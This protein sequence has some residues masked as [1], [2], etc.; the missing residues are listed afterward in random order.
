MTKRAERPFKGLMHRVAALKF[1]ALCALLA[2]NLT[3]AFW[4]LFFWCLLFAA[5]WLF[6]LPAVLGK[7]FEIFAFIVF[8]GGTLYL[9][10]HDARLFR[11]PARAEVERRLQKYSGAAHQPLAAFSDRPAFSLNS[12]V[13]ALWYREQQRRLSALKDLR[14]LKPSAFLAKRDPHALRALIVLFALCGFVVAG[15]E[16]SA[17]M[18][19]GLWPFAPEDSG[20]TSEN[21]TLLITPPKY[22]GLAQMILHGDEKNALSVPEGSAIK[23]IWRRSFSL[24]YSDPALYI[25]EQKL[26]LKKTDDDTF[27]LETQFTNGKR[28]SL[29]A[30]L[31]PIASWGINAKLDTPPQ[32]QITGEPKILP[33]GQIQIPV[34][35]LDDYGVKDLQMDMTLETK[36]TMA[37]GVDAHENRG[38]MS[39][40]QTKFEMTPV[41]DLTAHPWAG[42][43]ALITLSARDHKGQVAQAA[44]I[45]IT[46]PER[47]FTNPLAQ[48]LIGI[49]KNIIKAPLETYRQHWGMLEGFLQSNDSLKLD[50]GSRMA[51]RAAASRMAYNMPSAEVSGSLISLLW[52]TALH[53]EDGNLSLSARALKEAQQ[54]LQAALQDPN[55]SPQQIAQMMDKVREAMVDYLQS[56]A[57]EMQKRQA[58]GE[59][60]EMSPE[61]FSNVMDMDALAK[62]F[63]QME[64]DAMNGDRNAAQNLLSQLQRFLDMANPSLETA[65]PKDVEKMMEAMKDMQAIVKEQEALLD[66]T[67]KQGELLSMLD[68][69]GMSGKREPPPF[70][71]PEESSAKQEGLQKRLGDINKMLGDH[72]V[73]VPENLSSA[74]DAMK[75]AA[76][77][78][79]ESAPDIAAVQQ[80]EALRL[81]KESQDKMSQQMAQRMQ[82]MTGI[83][84]F[85]GG[86]QR[87]DPLGRPLGPDGQGPNSQNSNVKIPAEQERQRLQ[88]IVDELRRRAGQ[89]DRPQEE[90]EYYRR[91]LKRF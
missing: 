78:L 29:K 81:L 41:Y 11:W 15:P 91:L 38:V 9:L 79:S 61:M 56:L 25:D 44:P 18:M 62:M 90:L 80:R 42:M 5:L 74:E 52:D 58:A 43:P 64:A 45:K 49:R 17:R 50:R 22:T 73:P 24:P 76:L 47:V 13:T 85:S 83:S 3:L 51:M 7:V 66:E 88:S 16:R 1:V 53:I 4:R 60:Q 82:S 55:T 30:G 37:L 46:L 87:Y 39:P 34:T 69:M 28:L 36:I 32:I 48:D 20:I 63:D 26:A 19:R 84:F 14:L 8:T 70:M 75:D 54:E 35:L 21:I 72:G 12:D 67:M 77:S 40:A 6:A 33:Q 57:G 2:E 59:M 86:P 65:M 23:V 68:E 71:H 10:W 27:V 89:R 31:I